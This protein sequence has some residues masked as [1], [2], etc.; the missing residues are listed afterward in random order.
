MPVDHQG[1]RTPMQLT[2]YDYYSDYVAYPILIIGLGGVALAGGGV[3]RSL[4]WAAAFAGGFAFWTFA[5]YWVHRIVL[6]RLP[7]FSPMHGEHH[8]APLA[9][10]G[11]PTW[12][13]MPTLVIVVLAPAWALLGFNV[14]SGL[15]LGVCGGYVWYGLLHHL[16]HHGAGGGGRDLLQ[17]ARKRHFKHHYRPQAGNF[18]VT[19]ALWDHIFGT[20]LALGTPAARH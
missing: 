3:H 8:A 13:S 14:G 5:E 18:G 4:L 7:Y 10:I 9:F 17:G 15:F 6:H 20:A 11:T 1:V 19:T 16:I 12:I 2:K